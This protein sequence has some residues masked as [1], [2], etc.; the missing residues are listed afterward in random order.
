M[1]RLNIMAFERDVSRL[2][3]KI[4]NALTPDLLKPQY[5]KINKTNP[6]Y[7]HCYVATEALFYLLGSKDFSPYYGEDDNGIIHWWLEDLNGSRLDI[8]ADQY[9]SQGLQPPYSRG[10]RAAFLTKTPSK[11]TLIL[12][13]RISDK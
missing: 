12:I 7:G 10:K 2:I 1:G 4:K 13:G 6:T 3:S 9:I 8:T 5:R 11:R